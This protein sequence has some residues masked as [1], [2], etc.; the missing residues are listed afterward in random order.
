MTFGLNNAP[1][2]FQRSLKLIIGKYKC[3]TGLFYPEDVIIYYNYIEEHISRCRDI[4]QALGSQES[5]SSWKE[6]S[7]TKHMDYQGN[8]NGP[9]RLKVD[10]TR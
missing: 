1:A 3:K 4:I 7:F 5:P 9:G 8:I 2:T 10:S 6:T